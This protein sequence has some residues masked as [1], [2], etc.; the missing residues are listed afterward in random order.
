M[1]VCLISRF[2]LDPFG[3]HND[4][5]IW[6]ALEKSH[7]KEKLS[8]EEKQL[9]TLVSAAGQ[10][11]SVG[12]KQLICLARAVLRQN[13]VTLKQELKNLFFVLIKPLNTYPDRQKCF[14]VL[15]TIKLPFFNFSEHI[16]LFLDFTT[17]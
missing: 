11:L 5:K 12:E 15:S 16:L 4:D 10:N 2:N 17:R 7:L 1:A 8:R 6:E 9:Q 13:K 3:D 14:F